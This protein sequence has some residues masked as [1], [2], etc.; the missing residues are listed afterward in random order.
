MSAHFIHQQPKGFIALVSAL[1]VSLILSTI[2]FSV[3]SSGYFARLGSSTAEYKRVS[4][5]LAES[6]VNIAMLKA[7]ATYGY[8]PPLGGET[9]P[10]GSE[11]CVIKGVVYG[12]EDP[13]THQVPATIT[14][15]ASFRGAY[16]N[17]VIT[18]DVRNPTFALLARATITV[19]VHVLNDDDGT[20]TAGDFTVNVTGSDPAPISFPGSESGT[21][22][23]L[24]AGAYV[25]DLNTVAGYTKSLSA[26]CSG[27]VA[28]S[29]TR[30]CN[31]TV[32]DLSSAATLTLQANVVNDNG[33]TKLPT[34]FLL[35][36]D[37]TVQASGLPRSGLVPGVH[38]VAGAAMAGYARSV[39]GYHCA[40]N[41]TITLNVGENK[42]CIITYDDISPSSPICANTLLMLDRTGSMDPSGPI[43]YLPDER[44][45]AN[46]LLNL[47]L[48]LSPAPKLGIGVFNDKSNNS[49]YPARIVG[50][51]T[52]SYSPTL[53]NAIATWLDIAKGATNLSS[54]ISVSQTELVANGDPDAAG[55]V[56]ILISDGITN[57]P[58]CSGSSPCAEAI[59]AALASAEAA[60]AAGTKIYTIHFGNSSGYTFLASLANN[61]AVDHF[62]STNSGW[63][64]PTANTQNASGN[65]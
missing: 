23:S 48:P 64:A 9:V 54:A 6:C 24:N 44:V 39:W 30:V 61:S 17:M 21:Y 1:V 55:N 52:N 51:M 46:S 65:S 4:L 42:T 19:M 45:A 58:G 53:Y 25:V 20:N 56:I 29:E 49:S 22:V 7:A 37:G 41:G 8:V 11:T 43:N 10:V 57:R 59:N 32:D 50:P 47:Y 13:V 28:V 40:A 27:N 60:K 3:S 35:Q 16:S 31:I 26:D 38:L 14:T 2:A 63:R 33:G 36:I 34:D 5:G 15:Q 62:L 12:T 18:A